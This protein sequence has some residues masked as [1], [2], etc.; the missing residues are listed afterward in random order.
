MKIGKVITCIITSFKV[1]GLTHRYLKFIPVFI[2][3]LVLT[4]VINKLPGLHDK[5]LSII[6]E[7]GIQESRKLMLLPLHGIRNTDIL[8]YVFSTCGS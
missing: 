2:N 3:S 6:P 1:R 5:K 7:S 4:N 8:I